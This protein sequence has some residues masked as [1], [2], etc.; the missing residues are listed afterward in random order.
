MRRYGAARCTPLY[1][2]AGWARSLVLAPRRY[3]HAPA[4]HCRA[5]ARIVCIVRDSGIATP[6]STEEVAGGADFAEAAKKYLHESSPAPAPWRHGSPSDARHCGE[7]CR[8]AHL[9]IAGRCQL[10]G[11]IIASGRRQSRSWW[12]P[13]K[14]PEKA[15]IKVPISPSFAGQ[16]RL[17]AAI[18]GDY[19]DFDPILYYFYSSTL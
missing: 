4:Q 10:A 11:A 13:S 19:G 2:P 9:R 7:S 15:T 14:S 12:R 18:P 16:H 5:G 1:S 8:Q 17:S 6:A 3:Q